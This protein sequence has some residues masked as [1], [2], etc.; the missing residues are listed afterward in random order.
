MLCHRPLR[1]QAAPLVVTEP[2]V[3][4]FRPLTEQAAL[5][6]SV[7]L[8]VVLSPPMEIEEVR[9]SLRHWIFCFWSD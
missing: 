6:F 7:Q 9:K 4:C 2:M 5:L 8:V 1:A 3:P